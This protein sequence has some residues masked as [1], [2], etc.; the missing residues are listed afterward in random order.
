MLDEIISNF[1]PISKSYPST[2]W[3]ISSLLSANLNI[4]RVI[5]LV[6]WC[7]RTDQRHES[8]VYIPTLNSNIGDGYFNEFYELVISKVI[9]SSKIQIPAFSEWTKVV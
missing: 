7:K 5:L 9:K 8:S 1:I 2:N 4:D 6:V 3:H